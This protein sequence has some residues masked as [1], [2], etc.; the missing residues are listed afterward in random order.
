MPQATNTYE[1]SRLQRT[2]EPPMATLE[3]KPWRPQLQLQLRVHPSVDLDDNSTPNSTPSRSRQD[4]PS[5]FLYDS[6]KYNKP[7]EPNQAIHPSSPHHLT[8]FAND[9]IS[10]VGQHP[11]EQA[12]DAHLAGLKILLPGVN[13]YSDL[14]KLGLNPEDLD[15]FSPPRSPRANMTTVNRSTYGLSNGSPLHSTFKPAQAEISSNPR[16]ISQQSAIVPPQP[17]AFHNIGA[18]ARNFSVVI[19]SPPKSS[20]A[21][22]LVFE[23]PESDEESTPK[24]LRKPTPRNEPLQRTPA[25]AVP[26][27][28]RSRPKRNVLAIERLDSVS[29][30]ESVQKRR[31]RPPKPSETPTTGNGPKRRGRKPRLPGPEIKNQIRRPTYHKFICEWKDCQAELHNLETLRNHVFHVHNRKPPLRIWQCLW[32]KCNPTHHAHHKEEQLP[33]VFEMTTL[34]FETK[35]EWQDHINSAH[36]IP[37]AWSMGDGPKVSPLGMF[38]TISSLPFIQACQLFQKWCLT[39]NRHDRSS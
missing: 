35:A 38:P 27:A 22:A 25:S 1:P 14:L 10:A 4:R 8:P 21:K 12:L 29:A 9:V 39:V 31:G 23:V 28:P 7:T 6:V 2:T 15:L 30:T 16:R 34:K 37:V 33:E 18:Q 32:G 36:I 24:T 19:S 3:M 26:G 11:T 5:A 13:D 17:N 20:V